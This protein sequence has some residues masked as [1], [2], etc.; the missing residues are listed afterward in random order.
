MSRPAVTEWA[1][2]KG[3]HPAAWGTVLY[4]LVSV[5]RLPEV[6]PF[7]APLQ[8]GKVGI[9]LA[10]AGLVFAQR[11]RR[12]MNAMLSPLGIALCALVFVAGASVL[13]SI[14][15]T[16]TVIY[17]FDII[18]KHLL[19]FYLIAKSIDNRQ[20]VR[21]YLGSLVVSGA[22]LAFLAVRMGQ[23][24]GGRVE[25]NAAYDANDL[26]MIL[27]AILSISVAGV[28]VLR[29]T[30][31]WGVV[32]IAGMLMLATM[33]TGSRGGFLGLVA[34]GGY[35]A[36]TRFATARGLLT[37]RFSP[38]KFALFGLGA[39]VLIALV[40]ASTWERMQTITEPSTDYNVTDPDTGRL[41]I[42]RHGVAGSLDRPIGHG[43]AAFEVFYAQRTG[44][45]KAA[46]N[47]YVQLSVELG[48]LGL[49]L[50]LSLFWLSLRAT[51]R[52]LRSVQER[53]ATRELDPGES[54]LGSAATGLRGALLG[55]FVTSVFLSAAYTPLPYVLIAVIVGIDGLAGRLGVVPAKDERRR[56]AV[57]LRGQAGETTGR[58]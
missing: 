14:W 21:F 47:T 1:E 10:V 36:I 25:L 16:Y 19:M 6:V 55:Y 28:F 3:V 7:L 44:I 46:H 41:A 52:I 8:L 54:V 48:V 35:L 13:F 42:W 40:P 43:L 39:A 4:I 17:F 15:R 58:V 18:A 38:L 30:M 5:G 57:A 53:A 31:R 50:F 33:Y 34:V 45:Y 29:G 23:T 11:D 24:Y 9:V 27:V 51:G 32:V 12:T 49:A 22:M 20:M 26:A 2:P 37:R 56:G